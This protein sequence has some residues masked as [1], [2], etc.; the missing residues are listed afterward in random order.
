MFLTVDIRL[1]NEK[2]YMV[3]ENEIMEE[4]LIEINLKLAR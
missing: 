1:I 4:E 3:T 2:V